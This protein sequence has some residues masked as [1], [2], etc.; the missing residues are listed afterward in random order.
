MATE[1]SGEE[2]LQER[3]FRWKTA[4]GGN[5]CLLASGM[6]TISQG[7]VWHWRNQVG[8]SDG[9]VHPLVPCNW[10]GL[11]STV[12]SLILCSLQLALNPRLNQ[13]AILS[14]SVENTFIT[15]M[16]TRSIRVPDFGNQSQLRSSTWAEALE[17]GSRKKVARGTTSTSEFGTP[18]YPENGQVC[19]WHFVSNCCS[20]T[21][22]RH[23]WP[24]QDVKCQSDGMSGET[25]RE[26]CDPCED[27]EYAINHV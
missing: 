6:T 3:V 8:W 16:K 27:A 17:S 2:L 7:A 15:S 9:G 24:C 23:C 11:L 14:T 13:A 26:C 19:A 22:R 4:V 1:E 25:E 18:E 5:D 20:R 10:L 12:Y 21:R